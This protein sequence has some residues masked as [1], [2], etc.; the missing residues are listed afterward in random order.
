MHYVL[1]IY[2][3]IDWPS[4]PVEEKNRVHAACGA[5]HEDLVKR[6][7]T[8]GA[9]GLQPPQAATSLRATAGKIL[10]SDGPFIETKEVLGG[11]EMIEV[12]DREQA[13][14]IAKSFP[15]LLS[16]HCHVEV[17]PLVEGGECKD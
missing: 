12:R 2:Q 1:M 14:A 13:L 4:V 17:R 16:G 11:F 9:F 8:R 15:A 6:G 10:V 3:G 5:W 7:H